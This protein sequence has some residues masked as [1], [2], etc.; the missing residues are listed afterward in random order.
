MLI[1]RQ[2]EG[3]TMS[4]L[5]EMLKK[6][7]TDK[8]TKDK[9]IYVDYNDSMVVVEDDIDVTVHRRYTYKDLFESY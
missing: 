5:Y 2:N 4:M 8:E 7:A 9:I 1:Y 3:Y 6:R